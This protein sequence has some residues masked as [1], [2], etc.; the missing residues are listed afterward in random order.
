MYRVYTTKPHSLVVPNDR[1]DPP[2]LYPSTQITR[3]IA[4]R[5]LRMNRTPG[6]IPT[7]WLIALS[8]Y[9]EGEKKN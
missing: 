6:F 4:A 8:E 7:K 3:D 1:R 9:P 2:V 5:I